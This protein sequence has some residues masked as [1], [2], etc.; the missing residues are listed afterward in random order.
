MLL[1]RFR[2]RLNPGK[3]E[4][5]VMEGKCIS[6][7]ALSVASDVI[8]RISD[9]GLNFRV[10]T[11]V[12]R[13]KTIFSGFGICEVNRFARLWIK[14]TFRLLVA[15]DSKGAYP[16]LTECHKHIGLFFGIRGS[17]LGAL[18]CFRCLTLKRAKIGKFV[19]KKPDQLDMGI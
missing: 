9:V 4:K 10:D 16:H 14:E 17:W 7:I 15:W 8:D 12:V 2:F 19:G 1:M 6:L 3:L 18:G 13:F 5:T 11:D